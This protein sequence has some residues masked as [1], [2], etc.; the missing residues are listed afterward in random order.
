MNQ[1]INAP[2][3]FV[4][5]LQ[6]AMYFSSMSQILYVGE[7]QSIPTFFVR[8]PALLPPIEAAY[9]EMNGDMKTYYG[10]YDQYLYNSP[11]VKEIFINILSLLNAGT[12]ITIY[13]QDGNDL[14]IGQYLPIVFY[15]Y[16][17]LYNYE[18]VKDVDMNGREYFP[19]NNPLPEYNDT[20]A[21]LL[22]TTGN[23][24]IDSTTFITSVTKDK[25][26]QSFTMN[27]EVAKRLS[28]DYNIQHLDIDN[29]INYILSIIDK[30]NRYE[31]IN[32][33]YNEPVCPFGKINKKE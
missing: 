21:T 18:T 26:I 28:I 3:K 15:K 9:S 5:T 13:I 17:G 11:V 6:D 29:R 10:I 22:Y 12:P 20:I 1:L 16:F 24:I 27:D 23:G 25:I 8:V 2:I 31:N 7:E 19:F 4:N 30:Y 32:N 14:T 33:Q